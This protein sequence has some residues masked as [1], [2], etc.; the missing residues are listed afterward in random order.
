V[1]IMK[2]ITLQNILGTGQLCLFA[3]SSVQKHNSIPNLTSQW[4]THKSSSLANGLLKFHCTSLSLK[5]L[6]QFCAGILILI[7]PKPR[8]Y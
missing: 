6:N 4:H 7:Y 2:T 3:H 1:Q 8:V 5:C